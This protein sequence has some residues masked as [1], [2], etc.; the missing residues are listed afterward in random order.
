MVKCVQGSKNVN[1][2][3]VG[4]I[5]SNQSALK[6]DELTSALSK[7]RILKEEFKN[8]SEMNNNQ[9]A[10][11]TNILNSFVVNGEIQGKVFVEPLTPNY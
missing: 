4:G 10:E 9:L 1:Y 3:C 5:F 7:I 8:S 6:Q 11:T 2:Y